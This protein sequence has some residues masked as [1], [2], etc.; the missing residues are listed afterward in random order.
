MTISFTIPI[1]VLVA[2]LLVLWAGV[3]WLASEVYQSVRLSQV[4]EASIYHQQRALAGLHAGRR[5]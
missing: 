5:A 3:A 4:L 2:T 1:P